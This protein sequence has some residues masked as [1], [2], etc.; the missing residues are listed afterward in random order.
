VTDL[1]EV[2]EMPEV[3]LVLPILPDREESWRRLAQE[4]LEDRLGEYEALGKH[5]GIRRV[6]VY[7][8]R[9]P[10]WDVILAYVEAIDPAEAFRQFMASKDPFV[11]W[12]KEKITE[13][14]GCDVNRP[15]RVPSPEL[16]FE[17]PGTSGG[18]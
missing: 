8:V 5:V 18:S 14:N 7:L 10:R 9:M 15:R 16:I 1:K 11:G 17:H 6:R 2:A 13:L 12:L 3:V 4:L